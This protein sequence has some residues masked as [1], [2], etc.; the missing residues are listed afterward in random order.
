MN[1]TPGEILYIYVGGVGNGSPVCQYCVGAQ[2]AYN[3]GGTGDGYNLQAGNYPAGGGGGGTDI[4]I[5]G[6]ALT[7]RVLVA[8][9]GGGSGAYNYGGAG[10]SLSGDAG[11]AYEGFISGG[12]GGT[13][14]SGGNGGGNNNDGYGNAGGFGY[15]GNSVYLSGLYGGGGGGGYYGGGGSTYGGGGGG[16]SS[17]TDPVLCQNVVHTKGYQ[18]GNGYLTI[19]YNNIANCA[20]ATRQPVTLTVDTTP[21]VSAGQNVTTCLGTG[22]TLTA[23]GADTYGWQP[24]TF[25]GASLFVTPTATT[26]YTVTG[27]KANGGCTNTSQVTVT[28]SSTSASAAQTICAGQSATLNASGASNYTWQ[29]GNLTGS[30]VSVSPSVTTIYTVTGSN[31]SGCSTTAND[32][33]NVNQLPVVSAGTGVSVSAGASVTLTA[34]GADTYYWSSPYS[35]NVASITFTPSATSAW[36]VTGTSAATGCSN[37]ASAIV[38]VTPVT[39]IAGNTVICPGSTTTLTASGTAP[40]SWYSSNTSNTVLY[41]GATFTTPA[42]N[43]D[44]TYWVS[45]NGGTRVPVSITLAQAPYKAAATPSNICPSGTSALQITGYSQT[46]NWYDAAVGGNL[47]GTVT[48]GNAFSVTPAATIIYYAQIQAATQADT[49]NFGVTGGVQTFTVPAG[50]TSIQIDARGGAGADGYSDYSGGSG[51]NGGRVQSTMNVTPGEILYIY[52]GGVGNGSPVCQYCVGA[53]AAYNGGGTGDGYNLQAGNY[54]AGGGGGGTDIRINGQALTNRVLVA[55]GG[56]GSGAYNYG[57]AGGSLS[58]DAGAAYEGFISGGGGGTQTSGGNGGG[59]NNDGYGNAGGFGYGG[60]SVYLS[61]LYGGGGGGGYYGGGGSTYGGGGGGGSSYTDPV[62]CQN[63]VHTKGY[64]GG[65][66]LLTIVYNA[67]QACTASFTVSDTVVVR[68]VTASKAS[69]ICLGR[70][71]TLTASGEDSYTWQP[72]NL[73]GSSIAV[74]PAGTTIYTVTGYNAVGNCSTIAYDTVNVKPLPV[75]IAM[76]A[77]TSVGVN[78]PVLLTATGADAYTWSPVTSTKD[79]VTVA[80]STTA[81]YTVTG[82]NVSTGCSNTAQAL[83]TV[84]ATPTVTGATGLCPGGTTTLTASGTAP[85]NWYT[86]ATGGTPVYTGANFTTPVLNAN[87]SY[88]VAGNASDR[89][90]VN[91]TVNPYT[92]VA[93]PAICSGSSTAL[94]ITGATQT[95]NWYNAATGGNL[96][97]SVNGSAPF[98]VSPTN[99]QVYYAQMQYY[100]PTGQTAT[101][102][103]N[104]SGGAQQFTVPAGVTSIQVDASGGRGGYEDE[105]YGYGTPGK[106]GRVQAAMQVTPGQVLYVY[107]GQRGYGRNLSGGVN[108]AYNGGGYVNNT[109]YQVGGGGGGTDIRIGGQNLSNRVLVAGGGG[110]TGQNVTSGYGVGGGGGGATGAAG[111]AGGGTFGPYAYGGGGGTQSG[112]GAAGSYNIGSFFSANWQYGNAG[113]QGVGGAGVNDKT[114]SNTNGYW[115]GGGGGGYYGGGGAVEYGGGGGGSSYTSATLC[116]NVTHTQGYNSGDGQLIITYNTVNTCNVTMPDT[117]VVNPL[118]VITVHASLNPVQYGAQETLTAAGAVT[119]V[120]NNGIQNGVAFTADSSATYTVTGTDANG[121]TGA[122]TVKLFVGSTPYI[123]S[124]NPT[125]ASS[126]SSVTISGKYFTAASAVSFGGT[127]AASYTVVSDSVI[128]AVVGLGATG[129]VSV[130]APLGT[131][132]KAEFVYCTIVTPSVS[133][134][135]NFHSPICANTK[136]T[137]SATAVNGG[138]PVYQWYKNNAAVGGNT[139]NYVDSLLNNDDSVWCVITSTASC[140][141]TNTAKSNVMVYAVNP[142]LTPTLKV[143]INTPTTIC[144]GTSVTFTATATNTGANP[145]YQW[146]K[147]NI[148]VGTNSVTY[149]DAALNNKDSVICVLT[150]T[151]PCATPASITSAKMKFTVNPIVTPSVSIT[152]NFPSPICAKTKVTLTA[153]PVNAVTPAYQWYQNGKPVGGNTKNYIDSLI[154]NGNSIWCIITSSPGCITKDT[155]KSNILRYVVNPKLAPTLKVTINTTTSICAGTPV[156]FTATANNT[157]ANAIYQWKKNNINVGTDSTTYTDS[158]LKNSDS[159]ICVLTIT[160]PC[161]T[162]ASIT[163]GRLKFTV[164]STAPSQPSTIKGLASVTAGQTNIS[165]AVTSVAGLIYNWTVPSGVTIVSGQGTYKIVVNWGSTSGSIS[166]TASNS[167]GLSTPSQLTVTVPG[168]VAGYDPKTAL[169]SGGYIRAYPNPVTSMATIEFGATTTNKYEA[170]VMNSLG[171]LVMSK[172]G[173]TV[174][175]LNT[176]SLDMSRL[177]SA[178]YYVRLIDKEHGVRIIKLVKAK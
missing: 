144:A 82:T 83:V 151:A 106:G 170:Q 163:S 72:G 59:N 119:Y 118:P 46:V 107:V 137:F 74:S 30:S 164:A 121:C 154:G 128:N 62:L 175:G 167:C 93:P 21:T 168:T 63:V 27:T 117:V 115:G 66:G 157:G 40:F 153:N 87:T 5:N 92:A 123:T 22:V 145:T 89:L 97:G 124:F 3:G 135:S 161:A 127:A 43:A 173:L 131:A 70:N 56:G 85:F 143:T 169:L 33:I 20:A 19:T 159:V 158:T 165:Y 176:V 49:V 152:S 58:G 42:I 155:A 28:V 39:S 51:G 29:P 67:A 149:V 133:I 16:G 77:D 80:P 99:T 120:W 78:T 113:T 73:T 8:G 102:T 132:T 171:Q 44:T 177:A 109:V 6:Q 15:G 7:N 141:T 37:T 79:T 76:P 50:V 90:R 116:S 136:V 69:S 98:T 55:G 129:V 134:T 148:N 35:S 64:Q 101:Q 11:A 53:Q 75:V 126:G 61:G 140:V 94:T 25:T 60:N 103:F 12:G 160:A 95:V 130:T 23:T 156:T 178:M 100:L 31:P 162:P 54:P 110:G 9:G 18:G 41:T 174:P 96:L 91:I 26:T 84:I 65:N 166:V 125:T 112:G 105:T 142:K 24:G 71:D 10:G 13:Q 17:Y 32:T 38:T 150:I 86:S 104:Y 122:D 48:G 52:V 139:K 14:T 81:T 147:N 88:W 172:S 146:K 34:T 47:L 36:T 2:A 111:P 57:G 108:S 114:S 45:D 4:R 1:V 138:T 68:Q